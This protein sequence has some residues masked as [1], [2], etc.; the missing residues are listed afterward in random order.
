MS[1]TYS[2]ACIDCRKKLWIAQGQGGEQ[3]NNLR[4]MSDNPATNGPQAMFFMEHIRHRLIF[5]EDCESAILEDFDDITP[6]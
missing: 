5:D 3:P 6:D 4:V 1:F 2:I